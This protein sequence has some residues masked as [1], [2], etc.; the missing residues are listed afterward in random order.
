M[1]TQKLLIADTSEEFAQALEIAMRDTCQVIRCASGLTAL[2]LLRT[3][4][5][6]VLVVDTMLPEL[7]GI[8]LLQ[9]AA[10]ENLLPQ[11]L[12]VSRYTSDYIEGALQRMGISYFMFKP[13]R[14]SAVAERVMDL[15]ELSEAPAPDLQ[16]AATELLLTLG[17]STKHRGYDCTRE[18]VLC[19]V[20]DRTMPMTKELYP[21]VAERCHGNPK[22]VE[23]SIRDAI[24][25]AWK[26]KDP[27]VWHQY[28]RP[29]ADGTV[30]K[31]SNMAFLTRIAE[32]LRD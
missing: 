28:F 4:R 12:T 6:Q 26:R 29:C 19:L 16:S 25:S 1:K 23:K 20:R 22:Q 31:P 5:P 14:I 11:V 17:V 32:S 27:T 3:E 13:C 24:V 30:P 21:Q 10:R 15:L 8:T 9:T 18:A 2:E 7:D